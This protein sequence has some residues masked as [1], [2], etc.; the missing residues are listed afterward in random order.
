MR[1]MEVHVEVEVAVEMEIEGLVLAVR[2]R[3]NPVREA[4]N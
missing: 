1:M 2:H 3:R 4:P